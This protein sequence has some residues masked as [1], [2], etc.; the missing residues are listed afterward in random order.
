M[1]EMDIVYNKYCC[2]CS[3]RHKENCE[4]AKC[5]KEQYYKWLDEARKEIKKSK[6]DE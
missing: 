3:L 1:R 5:S 4:Y 6:E 2:R